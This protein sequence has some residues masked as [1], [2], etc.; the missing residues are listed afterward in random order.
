MKYTDIK[1]NK[2]GTEKILKNLGVAF[3]KIRNAI[4]GQVEPIRSE[5]ND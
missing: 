1:F 2:S 3:E 5:I 4:K